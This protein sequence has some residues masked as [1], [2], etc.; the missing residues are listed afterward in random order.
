MMTNMQI[1]CVFF[2]ILQGSLGLGRCWAYASDVT[3]FLCD[4]CG[5]T[6]PMEELYIFWLFFVY[7]IY[8]NMKNTR[9]VIMMLKNNSNYTV[10]IIEYHYIYITYILF[11]LVGG[12]RGVD[13]SLDSLKLY[14]EFGGLIT[15]GAARRGWF[16][17]TRIVRA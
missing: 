6:C 11:C 13:G 2:L 1:S 12:A 8:Q 9:I 3:E 7:K 16:N 5:R 10:Y 4:A 15:I 14:L 17:L